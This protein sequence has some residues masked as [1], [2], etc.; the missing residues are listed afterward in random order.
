[1]SVLIAVQQGRQGSHNNFLIFQHSVFH[2]FNHQNPYLEYPAEYVDIFLYNPSFPL[3]FLPFAYLPVTAG[4]LAWTIF[5]TLIFFFAIKSL[6]LSL[7][8]QLFIFYFI[9]PELNT[10]VSNL[11][12]NPLIAAFTILAMT[13]LEKGRYKSFAFFPALNFF[14]KGYGGIAGVFFFFNKPSFKKFMYVC[15]CFVLIGLLP[16]LFYTP[17]GLITLYQ[18]WFNCLF[19]YSAKNAGISVMGLIRALLYKD[20][21][22]AG[23]QLVGLLL[24]ATAF[25]V[26]LIK[27]NYRQMKLFFLAWVMIWMVIFNQVA[28]SPT[29][30]IAS[31]GVMI[32]YVNAAKTIADKFLFIFFVV[33]TLLS[34]TDLFPRYLRDNYVVPYCLKSLPCVLIWAKLQWHL[35]FGGDTI[36]VAE[37]AREIT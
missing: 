3:L 27:K 6:P 14:I 24:F 26:V 32:W 17:A 16:L 34:P 37:T 19:S 36:A 12:T 7:N 10:A 5:T 13:C 18:Q 30:L 31:T 29:Y 21:P 28:E 8:K 23:I 25:F 2:F 20:A 1:M 35:V 11:Q 4:I 22:V 9:I 15:G 33:I